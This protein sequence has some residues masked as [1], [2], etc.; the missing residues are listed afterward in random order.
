MIASSDAAYGTWRWR[1]VRFPERSSIDFGNN[2]FIANTSTPRYLYFDIQWR[3]NKAKP[4][5]HA[6]PWPAEN[7]TPSEWGKRK[8]EWLEQ[9]VVRTKDGWY[10][11]YVDGDLVPQCLV[12]ENTMT[13]SSEIRFRSFANA[14]ADCVEVYKDR[15]LWP[16]RTARYGEY[17]A[18]FHWTYRP[19]RGNVPAEKRK[20]I[21]VTG[22]D[23]RLWEIAKLLGDESLFRY[24]ENSKTAECSTDLVV[25]GGSG[26]LIEGETLRFRCRSPGSCRF[27]VKNGAELKIVNSTVESASA[28]PFFWM[29][30]SELNYELYKDHRQKNEWGPPIVNFGGRLIIKDSTIKN[31]GWMLVYGARQLVLENVKFVD[32]VNV[33]EGVGSRTGRG[34]RD[35]GDFR[36]WLAGEYAFQL[37]NRYNFFGSPPFRIKG[38]TFAGRD[39]PANVNLIGSDHLGKI[40][41]YDTDFSKAN[42][43]FKKHRR[44]F[45][46][47]STWPSESNHPRQMFFDGT[48]NLI[49]C[50]FGPELD[51][52]TDRAY[53]LPKYYLDVKVV[54]LDGNPVSGAFVEVRNEVDVAHPP[55][56]IQPETT[57]YEDCIDMQLAWPN[58][59]KWTK[60]RDLNDCVRPEDYGAFLMT[61]TI[62]EVKDVR[63]DEMGRV[64]HF[65]DYGYEHFLTAKRPK[66]YGRATFVYDFT[67]GPNGLLMSYKKRRVCHPP[68]KWV[69]GWGRKSGH[70]YTFEYHRKAGKV[71]GY[72]IT[73]KWAGSQDRK[74]YKN[75]DKI[76]WYIPLRVSTGRD[77]HIP[78][79]SDG[80]HAVVLT[81]YLKTNT[82]KKEFTYTIT[83]EKGNRKKVIRGVNPGPH[84]Y[85]VD[86][87]KPT[88]TI[89]VV[90]DGRTVRESELKEKRLAAAPPNAR[91]KSSGLQSWP[92]RH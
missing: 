34:F 40:D 20:G 50:R 56:N 63:K 75:V 53:V 46:W 52:Q 90:L 69:W 68:E 31:F 2:I 83:V 17:P 24:D 92:N 42:L 41:I 44:W 49:N 79:P 5:M 8:G 25:M 54:D 37:F 1:C 33:D 80:I 89:T 59:S 38:C 78:P 6:N 32:M 4:V 55:E 23:L 67:Y 19:V 62:G 11:R 21:L 29:F 76:K 39:A 86:P 18:C 15:C 85:R 77:G 3:S 57:T 28:Y 16:K 47:F 82:H 48:F 60:L 27:R 71:V 12:C 61:R 70:D 81:D 65:V 84:W 9:T 7:I 10:Y 91:D 26:L 66:V 88:Y 35:R 43:S 87:N 22:H 45:E 72:Y 30:T 74:K 73:E 51:I 14:Y 13:D 36:G 64:I 58:S